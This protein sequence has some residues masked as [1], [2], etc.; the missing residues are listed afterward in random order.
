MPKDGPSPLTA[1]GR[2]VAC[3]CGLGTPDTEQSPPAP[4]DGQTG[5][6][7]EA[8][9]TGRLSP[10]CPTH[11]APHLPALLAPRAQDIPPGPDTTPGR[12]ARNDAKNHRL[13]ASRGADRT[14]GEEQHRHRLQRSVHRWSKTFTDPRLCAAI[15][16]RL[17]FNATLIETGTEF[18]RLAR[19]KA[20]KTN[21]LR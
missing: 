12:A 1:P 5:R 19:T 14:R 3:P 20:H 11:G 13:S 15:V 10:T 2:G 6:A 18:Y 7:L 9:R 21:G 16:D 17:T 8:R 4:T